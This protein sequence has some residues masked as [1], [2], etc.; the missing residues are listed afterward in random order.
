MDDGVEARWAAWREECGDELPLDEAATRLAIEEG[1]A[2]TAEE[3]RRELDALAAGVGEGREAERLA[4]LVRHLFSGLGFE[5]EVL[6]ALRVSRMVQETLK[7][8][9]PLKRR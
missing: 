6:T 1:S 8:N 7:K 2:T 4:R 3:V 9:D 5:G